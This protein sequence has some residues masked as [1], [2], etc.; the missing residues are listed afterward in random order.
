MAV[1][2]GRRDR[3]IKIQKGQRNGGAKNKNNTTRKAVLLD[4]LQWNEVALPDRLDDA[5]GFFGL[6]EIEGVEIIRDGDGGNV[7]Y[8]VGKIVSHNLHIL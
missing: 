6:E 7:Q 4:Q 3:V 5:E 2:Q 1:T 8:R